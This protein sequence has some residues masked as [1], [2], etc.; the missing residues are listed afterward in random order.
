MDLT[1]RTLIVMGS[2]ASFTLA[3]AGAADA[4]RKDATATLIPN[5]PND[6]T[7][8]FQAA[9][10]DASARKVAL[11]IP[12]GSFRI[13]TLTLRSGSVVRGEG[14]L[15]TLSF[16]G[17]GRCLQAKDAANIALHDLTIDGGMRPL[18]ANGALVALDGCTSL[19]V[20]GLTIMRSST[21]ALNA[22]ASSGRIANCTISHVAD[23]AIFALDSALA[24]TGNTVHTCGNNGILVWRAKVAEDGSS[25]SD[26][27]ISGIRSDKGGSGQNGNG[28]NVYRAGNVSVRANRITDCSYS[29]IRGNAASNIQML[30]NTCQRIGE[31]ALYA[32]FGFE[33]ALIANNIVDRAAAGIS[34]TNFNEGGRLAVVQ[35]NLIRNL[36]RREQEPTDKRGEGISVEAD[37]VVSGNTIENAATVGILLGWGRHM[38]DVSATG[39]LVRNCRVGIMIS[40]DPSAGQAIVAN[41]VLSGTP[42]GAIRAMTNWQLIGP[43]L[44]KSAPTTGRVTV[45]GNVAG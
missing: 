40:A 12:A 9:I 25:V 14:A 8:A 38:R 11:D 13:G 30:G 21:N 18:D 5:S 31:V 4:A 26:N 7:A 27:I 28:V 19:D 36:V 34:V 35:G 22:K 17:S 1:R 33:G 39:N 32:E 15:T 37:S 24:I 23:A 3:T 42:D 41:N 20:H 2:G 6:Q 29:A 44:A 10:D 45:T 16:I 43:D